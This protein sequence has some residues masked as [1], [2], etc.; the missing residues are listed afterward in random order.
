M[1]SDLRMVFACLH[2]VQMVSVRI[3]FAY[4][5]LVQ[6]YQVFPLHELWCCT[7]LG[8]HSHM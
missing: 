2:L 4:L 3:L 7:I 6:T 8:L 5:H 1:V